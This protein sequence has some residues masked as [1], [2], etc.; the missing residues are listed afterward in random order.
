MVD[1]RTDYV[2]VV[3][4]AQIE[5]ELLSAASRDVQSRAA[6]PLGDLLEAVNVAQFAASPGDQILEL[7]LIGPDARLVARRRVVVTVAAS[8]VTGVTVNITRDCMGLVC[9]AA[10]GDVDATECFNAR[11]VP[12]SCSNQR[13][14][15]CGS[16]SCSVDADCS[17]SESPCATARC[18]GGSCLSTPDPGACTAQQVCVPAGCVTRPS[19][20]AGAMD[21]GSDAGTDAGLDA[22]VDAGSDAGMDAGTDA[23]MDAGTDAGMDAGVDAGTDAGA[24][25]GVDVGLP[26]LGSVYL[27]ASTAEGG[28][29]FGNTL[30]LSSDGNTLAV[31]AVNEASGATGVGGDQADNS[32]PQAGAV[33]VF[34]RSAGVWSQQAYLKASNAEM[35][36]RFGIA[37]VLSSDGS[38]LVV[39][40][41][42][43]D[44]SATGS[45]GDQAD[46]SAGE[47]GAAYVFTRSA[48]VWSQQ[49]Y[50]KASNSASATDFGHA[51]A[52]SS[53]GD[54]LA[55]GSPGEH[56]SATGV[57]GDQADT[58]A[59]SSGAAYV[60]TR[61]AGIWSQQAYVKASNTGARDTFGSALGL[62][63]DGSTLAVGAPQ[64]SSSATGVDGEQ[65]DDSASGAGAVYMF[66]RSGGTW[67][68]SSYLKASNA[69]R[70]DKFGSAL[71][72]SGDGSSLAVGAP[73]EAS[74]ARGVG[75]D[76]AS[77]SLY[78][79]G[80]VYVFSRV[81]AT[82]SQ[83]A[84]L[85]ASNT[86][87]LNWFGW[88]LGLSQRGS[89]LAVGALFEG[90]NATGIDGDEINRRAINAGAAYLFRRSAATWS[91]VAYLKASNTDADD[92]FG[93]DLALST[94]ASTLAI[95]APVEA[96]NATGIGGDQADNSVPSA[97][98]VYVF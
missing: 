83:Q 52:L 82:W 86:A 10:G 24:D 47:S 95:G 97:G 38:T 93:E 46:N 11:C 70:G 26:G 71:A 65:M 58:A 75:G 69:E 68:Q 41:T 40:A 45:G 85:K 94:D 17:P 16:A 74:G 89:T 39:S 15:L 98:A 21:A 25:A 29:R 13:P 84:Y 6:A 88:S 55:V 35:N 2:S 8:G 63:G 22:A 48:G 31:S 28:D 20:D 36:D 60:F 27:K 61:S 81:G 18:M 76:Q 19:P 90:S 51:L 32:A 3:E 66:T 57:G 23:G 43:E 91:Q 42:S 64:E 50:L 53:D 78:L 87:D 4:V 37:L 77:N 44:S 73:F 14:E 79:A 56:S 67:S 5:T 59:P 92:E 33:Y 49:A 96:S 54:T 7:R 30:A 62:S 9:P 34:T 12:P 80:A 1:L 72:L